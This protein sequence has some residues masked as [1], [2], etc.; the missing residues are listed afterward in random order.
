MLL[1]GSSILSQS[2]TFQFEIQHWKTWHLI[3]LFLR[4]SVLPHHQIELV[5]IFSVWKFN[6]IGGKE[7]QP[8]SGQQKRL[9]KYRHYIFQ[10]AKLLWNEIQVIITWNRVTLLVVKYELNQ[11]TGTFSKLIWGFSMT[12]PVEVE[13]FFLWGWP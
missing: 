9:K 8:G 10:K 5:V 6:S 1:P 11:V 3:Q 4:H 13:F 2:R 12:F 7:A